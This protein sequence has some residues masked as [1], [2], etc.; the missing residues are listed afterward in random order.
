MG[1]GRQGEAYFERGKEE[2][3]FAPVIN[4]K[5]TSMVLD[6]RH[7]SKFVSSAVK[8]SN[9]SYSKEQMERSTYY[10]GNYNS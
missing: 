6:K 2:L 1:V 7:L 10:Y 8:Q 4:S 5:L 9:Y 3:S